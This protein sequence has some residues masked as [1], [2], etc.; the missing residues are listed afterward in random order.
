MATFSDDESEYLVPGFDPNSLTVPKIRNILVSH[1]IEFPSSSKKAQ[2]VEIFNNQLVPRSGRIRAQR[3]RIKRTS[4]G[5]TDMPSSQEETPA[6]RKRTPSSKRTSKQTRMSDG[7]AID[8]EETRPSVRRSR[9][10]VGPTVVKQEE[11]EE[12]KSV[13]IRP[14][15]RPTIEKSPFSDDNPFQSG[16][17]P[18]VFSES[19]R[20]SDTKKSISGR[21]KTEVPLPVKQEDDEVPRRRK[22][23]E[24]KRNSRLSTPKIEPEDPLDAGE[25][26]TPEEQQALI[27]E[28]AARGEVDVLSRHK[29]RRSKRLSSFP[30]SAPL[31]ML[32]TLL[33]GYAWWWRKEKIEIGYCGIGKESTALSNMQVP[34]WV[35]ILEPQ[36]ELCPPHATCYVDMEARC[37]P[38][39][40]LKP[41]PLALGGLVPL[42]P[43]CEPDGEK[44]RKVKAVA[45]RA[46]EELRERRAKWECGEL[47]KS[48]GKSATAL[49]IEEVS[50]KAEVSQ[51][52]RRGMSAS[53]FEE[54]WKGALGEIMARDEVTGHADS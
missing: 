8:P 33:T 27:Q 36:C 42:L 38:D 6:P 52:R 10:S 13:S 14:P 16:S 31:I 41:H 51:K 34:D 40:V 18:I 43:S 2:L 4:N 3:A 1:D 48:D 30:K 9:R 5:I 28:G 32:M 49:E 19:K 47:T 22:S 17:S 20:K 46:V 29:L 7:E 23:A 11:P 26:F 50:L 12:P 15:I 21:R 24:P 54:L 35:T 45:D 44:A 37:D 53:E 25:E 39:F